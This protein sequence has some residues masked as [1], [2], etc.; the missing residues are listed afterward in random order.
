MLKKIFNIIKLNKVDNLRIFSS[1]TIK[2]KLNEEI[3]Y[4]LLKVP[5][6]K[7]IHMHNSI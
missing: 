4:N 6:L 5:F 3:L 1:K 7:I 2:T